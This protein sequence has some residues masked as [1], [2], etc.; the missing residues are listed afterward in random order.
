MMGRTGVRPSEYSMFVV[1]SVVEIMSRQDAIARGLKRYFTGVP[2]Q[3]GHVSEYAVKNGGCLACTKERLACYKMADP[4]GWKA[5]HRDY[6][7]KYLA[8]RPDHHAEMYA[9]HKEK[10]RARVKAWIDERPGYKT[11]RRQGSADRIRQATPVWL[12]RALQRQI[13]AIYQ[14]AASRPG[15]PWHVDHIIPLKG[16][17]VCGLHVPWNLQILAK[18]ENLSKG[19][20]YSHDAP[21]AARAA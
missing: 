12:D 10:I 19:K 13:D 16:R 14:E 17:G 11:S 9:K 15:G 1:C 6:N 5:R 3:R 7:R 4:E 8:D 21:C 2:C 18:S 20:S